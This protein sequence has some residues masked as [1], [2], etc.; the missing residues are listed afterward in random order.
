[1]NANTTGYFG[2]KAPQEGHTTRF[3]AWSKPLTTTSP[4]GRTE[5]VRSQTLVTSYPPMMV[6]RIEEGGRSGNQPDLARVV[7]DHQSGGF[8]EAVTASIRIP[9]NPAY[10]VLRE[11]YAQQRPVAL[12]VEVKRRAKPKGGGDAYV[13]LTAPIQGLRGADSPKAFAPGNAVEAGRNASTVVAAVDGTPSTD[14]ASIPTEWGYLQRNIWGNLAPEGWQFLGS[15]NPEGDE[16]RKHA[17]LVSTTD[18]S[19]GAAISS[20]ELTKAVTT[21][22]EA[23][24]KRLMPPQDTAPTT[25]GGT[26]TA[27]KKG[28][29]PSM[30]TPRLSDGRLNLGWIVMVNAFWTLEWI[31]TDAPEEMT[32]D[33]IMGLVEYVLNLADQVQAHAYGHDFQPDRAAKSYEL[34][35]RALESACDILNAPVPYAAYMQGDQDEIER[36]GSTIGPAAVTMLTGL[37]DMTSQ[38]LAPNHKHPE[39][40]SILNKVAAAWDDP[41]LLREAWAE[42]HTAGALETTVTVTNDDGHYTIQENPNGQ[43]LHQAMSARG[44]LLQA[45]TPQEPADE[46]VEPVEVRG[47][48]DVLDMGDGTA[49]ASYPEEVEVLRE[50]INA[51]AAARDMGALQG[52]YTQAR[53]A[54]VL[55]VKVRFNGRTIQA[56]A[57]T[58]FALVDLA[59][60]LENVVADVEASP[61]APGGRPAGWS[62]QD[63]LKAAKG[64]QSASEVA[65]LSEQAAAEGL[66]DEVV[67]LGGVSGPL[68]YALGHLAETKRH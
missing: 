54:G 20:D 10:E 31:R 63:Y 48:Q 59:D 67:E 4:R 12:T 51:A 8:R 14:C 57:R 33:Q 23:A 28:R 65:E 64:A 5:P 61:A 6:T 25:T 41:A 39:R 3:I 52:A 22:V 62:A 58:E 7:M 21:A 50:R 11:A 17:V 26:R 42:A 55:G 34:A 66:G 45:E 53:S 32:L 56:S 44:S 9:D 13:S 46:P 15:T 68:H 60:A 19:A 49:G 35:R 38:Y 2:I 40:D 18:T 24:F 36:W 30:F 37:G 27:P 43:P 29:E 47:T 16:W 1:M